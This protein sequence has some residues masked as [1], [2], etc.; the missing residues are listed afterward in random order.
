MEAETQKKLKNLLI[1]LQ[2]VSQVLSSGKQKE[3]QDPESIKN[4]KL[5]WDKLDK[6][7]GKISEIRV[8][9]ESYPIIEFEFPEKWCIK[10]CIELDKLAKDLWDDNQNV[11]MSVED[12]YFYN[13]TRYF[14]NWS[15]LYSIPKGYTEITLEQFKQHFNL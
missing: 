11:D 1:E 8:V 10:G 15:Y 9:G 7:H 6:I 2:Q 13:P 3:N 5:L 14:V 12:N 4:Y